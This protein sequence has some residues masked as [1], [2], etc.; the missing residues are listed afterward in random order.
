MNCGSSLH[1][2]RSVPR[3]PLPASTPPDV[4]ILAAQPLQLYSRHSAPNKGAKTELTP[5]AASFV[6]MSLQ[7]PFLN[8]SSPA[9]IF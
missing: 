3:V 4:L 9:Q 2:E 5:T 7:G 1:T 8:S 6:G